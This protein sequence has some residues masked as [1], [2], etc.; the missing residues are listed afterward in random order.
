MSWLTIPDTLINSVIV[1]YLEKNGTRLG[2]VF[3]SISP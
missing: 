3:V 2:L 1:L